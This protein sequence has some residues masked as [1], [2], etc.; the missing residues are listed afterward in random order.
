MPHVTV[1][2]LADNDGVF[3]NIAQ[4]KGTANTGAKKYYPQINEFLTDY[5]AKIKKPLRITESPVDEVGV[6]YL[7]ENWR[8]K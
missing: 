4:I 6:P 1:Q 5:S 3:N 2:V 8:D 7:P